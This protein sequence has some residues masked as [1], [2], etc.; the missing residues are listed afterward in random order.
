MTT[1][2]SITP[3]KP[4][5]ATSAPEASSAKPQ[6]SADSKKLVLKDVKAKWGK[7]S[8]QELSAIKDKDDLVTQ[9]AAKYGL[10]KAQAQSDVD[11]V[12]KDRQI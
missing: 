6:V 3:A 9:V 10:D 5:A 11:G 7:F 8:E 12:L 2:P 1:A 4:E